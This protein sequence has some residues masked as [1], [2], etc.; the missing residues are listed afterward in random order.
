MFMKYT[1]KYT[2][3]SKY[4]IENITLLNTYIE[5]EA[6][7]HRTHLLEHLMFVMLNVGVGIF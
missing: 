4:E 7:F 1:V 2:R 5:L 6:R 3:N